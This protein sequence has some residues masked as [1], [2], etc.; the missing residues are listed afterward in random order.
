MWQTITFKT[1]TAMRCF[2]T[3]NAHRYQMQE[4]FIESGY[5]VEF[6]QFRVID[7]N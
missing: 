3:A 5:G 7:I 1:K 2:M 6:R 4:I